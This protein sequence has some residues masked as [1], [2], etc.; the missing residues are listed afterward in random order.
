MNGDLSTLLTNLLTLVIFLVPVGT[1]FWKI[2]KY[3]TKMEEGLNAKSTEITAL[4][5]RIN[6]MENKNTSGYKEILTQLD[7]IKEITTLSNTTCVQH[8]GIL[9]A[10]DGRITKLEERAEELAASLSAIREENAKQTAMLEILV[11]N[12]PKE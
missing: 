2:A 6:Y 4:K 1:L 11:K 3:S 12:H 5:D 9:V 7:H 8:D 10:H